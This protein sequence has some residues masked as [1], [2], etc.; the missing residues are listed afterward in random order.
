MP[1]LPMLEYVDMA[2]RTYKWM[3]NNGRA[4]NHTGID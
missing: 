1:L 2:N 3:D 4:P